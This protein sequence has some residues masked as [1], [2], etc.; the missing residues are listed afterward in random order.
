MAVSMGKGWKPKFLLQNLSEEEKEE[1]MSN[2]AWRM[3]NIYRQLHIF[4]KE[5]IERY[6]TMLLETDLELQMLISEYPGG[7]EVTRYLSYIKGKD[8]KIEKPVLDAEAIAEEKA[9]ARILADAL[10]EA[11]GERTVKVQVE[12]G[13][14]LTADAAHGVFANALPPPPAAADAAALHLDHIPSGTGSMEGLVEALAAA[15]AK[16]SE[17]S[18]GAMAEAVAKAISASQESSANVI[19]E[20]ISRVASGAPGPIDVSYSPVSPQP[21]VNAPAPAESFDPKLLASF[22]SDISEKI[23]AGFASVLTA[24]QESNTKALAAIVD[25]ISRDNSGTSPEAIAT[26]IAKGLEG[27]NLG[28]VK[29][30][31]DRPL[32]MEMDGAAPNASGGMS[33]DMVA[34]FAKAFADAQLQVSKFQTSNLAEAFS[35]AFLDA[36]IQVSQVQTDSLAEA[37]A[38]AVTVSQSEM[39][40]SLQ[41]IVHE[42]AGLNQSP[43]RPPLSAG[44]ISDIISTAIE[45]LQDN[46]CIKGE[47]AEAPRDAGMVEDLSASIDKIMTSFTQAQLQVSR[48]QIENIEKV[49]ETALGKLSAPAAEPPQVKAA[50]PAS[51]VPESRSGNTYR[52]TWLGMEYSGADDE[53]ADAVNADMFSGELERTEEVSLKEALSSDPYNLL[54]KQKRVFKEHKLLYDSEVGLHIAYSGIKNA[55]NDG[56]EENDE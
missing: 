14:H 5:D 20:A 18:A 51:D 22:V 31:I 55:E 36:Q 35:K 54:L 53:G 42:L 49:L 39:S 3:I 40:S 25:N 8:T 9:K 26:A 41:E 56:G 12:A 17:K 33:D 29:M 30:E 46:I 11:G 15:Q 45:K 28:S 4:T 47:F 37:F 19:A 48:S 1:T 38:K 52:E 44:D 21:Y 2:V 32:K 7:A 13:S 34:S 23:T 16:A 10:V 50:E 43:D 24:S 27:I 6:N